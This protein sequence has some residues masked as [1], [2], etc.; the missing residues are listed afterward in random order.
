MPT[1]SVLSWI[2]SGCWRATRSPCSPGLQRVWA[3]A[4]NSTCSATLA[5]GPPR[6]CLSSSVHST[7]ATRGLRGSSKGWSPLT[8]SPTS[9][10]SDA[11][12]P[13]STRICGP[14][15]SSCLKPGPT[16]ATRCS[17]SSRLSRRARRPKNLI[18]ASL[19]KPDIR[20]RDAIDND[21]EILGNAGDV[22]VYDRPIGGDGIRWRT[23]QAWWKDTQQ[24]PSEDE[25]KK[26]LYQRLIRSLPENSPPQRN[27]YELYHEIHGSA[28]QDLPALLPEVWLH[29]DPK[30]VGSATS[31]PPWPRR[32]AIRPRSPSPPCR[33]SAGRSGTR[34]GLDRAAPGQHHLDYLF[35]D[36]SF[37]RMH[38]GSPA[39]PV[40]AAWGIT[41]DGKPAFIGLAPGTAS[42]PTPGQ[43]SSPTSR[44]AA[45]PPRCWSSATEPGADRRDRAGLAEGPAP[46]LSRSPRQE[47]PGEGPGREQ[48]EIKDA[49]WKLFDTEGLKTPPG[50]RLVDSSTRG[51]PRWPRNTRP[52]T[53]RR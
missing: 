41:T 51:S 9:L 24:L 20:F 7:R 35:L 18:F 3:R 21:I 27:L 47:C 30:T 43:P 16:A 38:P 37:F 4:S 44:T 48:A 2:A 36:A 23:L 42:P 17:A 40:L 53:R 31:K 39:E 34:R 12:L 29:W 50:P 10:R 11:S 33:R 46:A 28:V 15:G 45:W 49:Y 6:T 25:A 19:A 26:S 13:R 52:R 5:T 14:R 8:S 32:W 1:G 22:L